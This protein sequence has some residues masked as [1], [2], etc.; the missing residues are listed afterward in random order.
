M[1]KQE[2]HR[3]ALPRMSQLHPVLDTGDVPMAAQLHKAREKAG[4]GVMY[5]EYIKACL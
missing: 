5:N 4:Y 2:H 3:T 1:G